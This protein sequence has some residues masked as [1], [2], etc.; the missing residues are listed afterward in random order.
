MDHAEP[1]RLERIGVCTHDLGQLVSSGM[2]ECPDGQELVVLVRDLAKIALNHAD[3]VGK[4]TAL[5]FR[6][7]LPHLLGGRIDASAE[8]PVVFPRMMQKSTPTRTDIDEC[9][10][11]LQLH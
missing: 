1:A 11:R 6:P 2:L 4:S 3:L 7:C 8:R 10:T 5:Y 9:L